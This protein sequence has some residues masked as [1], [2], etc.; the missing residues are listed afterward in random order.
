MGDAARYPSSL[1]RH[2]GEATTTDAEFRQLAAAAWH[3]DGTLV[4]RPG[5]TI[6]WE[7]RSLIDAIG[8]RLYGQRRETK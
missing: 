8:T 3:R 6:K 4:L 5:Q 7:D 2:V 1:A